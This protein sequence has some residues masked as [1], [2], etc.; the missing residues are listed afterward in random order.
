MFGRFVNKHTS[1]PVR[2]FR[3]FFTIIPQSHVA[4]R[5][6][7][8][9]GRTKLEPGIHLKL[10]FVHKVREFTMSEFAF[11]LDGMNAYTKD[12][13]PIVASGTL[14]GRIFDPELAAYEV[15]NFSLSVSAVGSS[16]ARSIIGCYEY[17]RIIC[18]RNILTAAM[19]EVVG[20][21]IKVWGVECTRFELQEFG[22]QND[23]V[24]RQMEKQMEAER[25]RRENELNTQASIRT[26]EGEKT[27][28][29]LKSEGVLA[30]AENE[31][32]G[33][34]IAITRHAE[35]EA[36]EK[37]KQADAWRDQ[38]DVLTKSL[39]STDA[40]AAFLLEI[41]RQKNLQAIAEGSNTKVY[42]V[43]PSGML[44]SIEIV[45]DMFAEKRNN[46]VI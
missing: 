36:Y 45:A 21:T 16:A 4:F 30:A 38:L 17:D 10:P 41:Q 2:A 9:Q 31:A 25:S 26:A 43:P 18:E 12:N 19:R 37:G 28:A 8:G 20:D 3:G 14:F 44:P 5:E 42:F 22:P 23:H 35:A 34:Y 11:P 15:E 33:R 29:I 1:L 7:L 32:K 27:S 39:G 13:V 46:N 24:A 40:A 6:F